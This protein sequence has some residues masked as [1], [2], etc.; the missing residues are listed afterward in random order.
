MGLPCESRPNMI[1]PPPRLAFIKERLKWFI[2][3]HLRSRDWPLDCVQLMQTMKC[4]QHLPFEYLI[5]PL[6]GPYGAV[7]SCAMNPKRYTLH[8]NQNAM[9]YPFQTS[10]DRRMNFILAREIGRIVLDQ[11]LSATEP[12]S[13]LLKR[14]YYREAVEFADRLLMPETLICSCNYY[15]PDIVAA[16][17]NVSKTAL[18]VRIQNLNRPDLY[19]ARIER[20]CPVCGNTAFPIF[21][22]YCCICGRHLHLGLN[23]VRK[24]TY[25]SAIPM[26]HYKRVTRCPRC[27]KD[28]LRCSGGCCPVCR[29]SIFNFCSGYTDEAADNLCDHA[30]PANARYCEMCGRPTDYFLKGL[31]KPWEEV[32][33]LT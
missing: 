22:D 28:L 17:L 29:L 11:P 24:I 16:Y 33:T 7:A 27:Y 20:T 18:Q 13:P 2:Q 12:M 10:A 8:I 15:S 19:N 5:Q 21:T 14:L 23:G 32:E 9:A 1:L 31:M 25:L 26:D 30:N 3:Q 6:P 4:R